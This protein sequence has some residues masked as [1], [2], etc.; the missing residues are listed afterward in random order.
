MEI[1]FELL[2]QPNY[3][4]SVAG[5]GKTLAVAPLSPIVAVKAW[6][7]DNLPSTCSLSGSKET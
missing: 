1:L 7:A 3:L 5:T 2:N 4:I 6:H